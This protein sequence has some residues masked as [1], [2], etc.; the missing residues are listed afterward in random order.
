[1]LALFM[2][3]MKLQ[4]LVFEKGMFLL[5]IFFQCFI[6][7]V[8]AAFLIFDSREGSQGFFSFAYAHIIFHTYLM[9]LLA[10]V[11]IEFL[12]LEKDYSLHKKK[13]LLNLLWFIFLVGSQFTLYYI[14]H[15]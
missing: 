9:I 14:K 4:Q 5:K 12:H 1:M 6:L 3:D 10:P 11:F 7:P 8:F 2:E 15:A 13:I